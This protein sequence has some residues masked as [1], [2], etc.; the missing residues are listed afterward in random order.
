MFYSTSSVPV[1]S[2][3]RQTI[4]SASAKN[5]SHPPVGLLMTPKQ[6]SE[7]SQARGTIA[8]ANQALKRKISIDAS[9]GVEDKRNQAGNLPKRQAADPANPTQPPAIAQTVVPPTYDVSTKSEGDSSGQ[10]CPGPSAHIPANKPLPVPIRPQPRTKP[11][12]SLF[13]NKRPQGNPIRRPSHPGTDNRLNGVDRTRSVRQR[14][15]EEMNLIQK[16]NHR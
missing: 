5:P 1:I 11:P 12:P 7:L 16:P 9:D 4:P 6:A 13:I 2:R 3:P 10:A 15:Q 14:M 8:K